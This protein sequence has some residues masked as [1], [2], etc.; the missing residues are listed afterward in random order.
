MKE[1]IIRFGKWLLDNRYTLK[2]IDKEGSKYGRDVGEAMI[3]EKLFEK[4]EKEEKGW[5]DE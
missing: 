4:F 1:K 3:M 5:K 2:K